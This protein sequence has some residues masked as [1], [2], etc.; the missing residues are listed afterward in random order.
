MLLAYLISLCFALSHFADIVLFYKLKICG[1]SV[2]NKSIGAIF[3]TDS[4]DSKNT[5]FLIKD[6]QY[7]IN[8]NSITHLI[9]YS[10]V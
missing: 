10:T 1:K 8:Y 5:V 6:I 2:L 9:E 7:Y 3:P 4:G